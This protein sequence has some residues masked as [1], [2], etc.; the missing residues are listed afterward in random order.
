MHNALPDD[1]IIAYTVKPAVTAVKRAFD[2]LKGF[3]SRTMLREP[4]LIELPLDTP[5]AIYLIIKSLSDKPRPFIVDLSG[6]MRVLTLYVMTALL[7][8]K[9]DAD[10]YVQ[11][12][13]GGLTET[14]IPKELFEFMRKPV[15][16]I[17]LEIIGEV[18]KNP[19]VTIEELARITKKSEKTIR[20]ILSRLRKL[21]I[22]QKGRKAGL[23]PTKWVKILTPIKPKTEE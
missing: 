10:I 1:W 14:I 9:E 12:E 16:G 18:S 2:G 17:E 6:G 8:M 15:T 5:N 13:S 23:Y 21:L 7:L 20:N 11:P 4:L 19:G 22:T 3:T